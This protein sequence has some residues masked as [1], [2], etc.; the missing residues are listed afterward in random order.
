MPNIF[1]IDADTKQVI[2]DALDD[3]L[4]NTADG[5]LGKT[6]QLVYPPR[7]VRC[8]NCIFDPTNNRSSNRPRSGGPVPF[9]VGASCPLCSGRGM[10][11][12]EAT[13]NITLKCNWEFKKFA[14]SIPIDLR[15]P[16]A[17]VQVKG[18]LT[19]I[20]KLLRAQYVVINLP[21]VPY[22]RQSFVLLGEPADESNI[23]Q[24][25]YFSALLRRK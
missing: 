18:Y 15:I 17:V 12:E 20:P 21:F 11:E 19:D 25:R 13:E 4:A 23:V 2:Q 24:S 16:N 14:S 6:C 7:Q 8:G 10:K 9:A 22:A 3:L 1:S 5:G